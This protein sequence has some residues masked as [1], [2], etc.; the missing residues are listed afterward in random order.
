MRSLCGKTLLASGSN[1]DGRPGPPGAAREPAAAETLVTGHA[2]QHGQNAAAE[3]ARA[4]EAI[5]TT[6]AAHSSACGPTG[7]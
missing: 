7:H 2:A 3:L 6:T 4:L 1:G 5:D